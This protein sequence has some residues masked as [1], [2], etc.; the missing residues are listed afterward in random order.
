[1]LRAGMNVPIEP[2]EEVIDGHTLL[3][4]APGARHELICGRLHQV[5]SVHLARAMGLTLL[6]RRSPVQLPAGHTVRPD[7]AIT[8]GANGKLWLVGEVVSSEDHRTDTVTKK[9]VYEDLNVPRLWM[10]DPRYDNVE[11]YHGS[12]YGLMLK[13]ILA[14]RE[15]LTDSVLPNLQIQ[16]AELFA[17]T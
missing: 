11:V 2:Y 9:A 5:L 15:R 12:E 7:L 17:A 10:V 6:E 14:G 8:A 1:M 16:I 3:R 4:L 13:G